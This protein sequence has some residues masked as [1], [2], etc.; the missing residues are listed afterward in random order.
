LRLQVRCQ[1][2]VL[3]TGI[4]RAAIR[5]LKTSQQMSPLDR[6]S[7]SLSS[8]LREGALAEMKK[9]P[10]RSRVEAFL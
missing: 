8:Y 4:E 3:N 2:S 7:L 1:N 9:A 10:T 6:L 5:P